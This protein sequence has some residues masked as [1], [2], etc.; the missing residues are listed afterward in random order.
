MQVRAAR[1]A[2]R[3]IA[4]D[5]VRLLQEHATHRAREANLLR[6]SAR[7]VGAVEHELREIN[8][9]HGLAVPDHVGS[10]SAPMA[11]ET[12]ASAPRP[13]PR[14]TL[15][16][17]ARSLKPEVHRRGRGEPCGQLARPKREA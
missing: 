6:R 4:L 1:V 10:A 17:S 3:Q 11:S 13:A 5:E 15:A 14:G 9:P 8:P 12:T 16:R 2:L 7:E